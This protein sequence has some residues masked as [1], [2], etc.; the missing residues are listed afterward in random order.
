MTS[1]LLLNVGLFLCVAAGG[2]LAAWLGW[3]LSGD[4]EH[5]PGGGDGGRAVGVPGGPS[6]WAGPDD[7]A[8]SA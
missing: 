8:R 1:L 7:L 5:P 4:D 3:E 6:S 2:A